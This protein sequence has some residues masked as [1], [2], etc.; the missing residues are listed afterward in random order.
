MLAVCVRPHVIYFVPYISIV[1]NIHKNQ[2]IYAIHNSTNR[3][4]PMNNCLCVCVI[5]ES[6]NMNMK[7][8]RLSD[9]VKRR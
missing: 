8:S 1:T 3:V 6:R 4:R 9:F 2:F 5:N 7:S